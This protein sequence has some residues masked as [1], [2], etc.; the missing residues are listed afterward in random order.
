MNL[1][2]L[3]QTPDICFR[4]GT[5]RNLSVRKKTALAFIFIALAGC[6]SGKEQEEESERAKRFLDQ[7]NTLSSAVEQEAKAVEGKVVDGW[8]F[9]EDSRSLKSNYREV[10]PAIK[11]RFACDYMVWLQGK[12]ENLAAEW[13]SY[14]PYSQRADF[15]RQWWSNTEHSRDFVKEPHYKQVIWLHD[16]LMDGSELWFR[17]LEQECQA[18]VSS[19]LVMAHDREQQ[20]VAKYKEN[21]SSAEKSF[22]SF[23]PEPSDPESAAEKSDNKKSIDNN[24]TKNSST[25]NNSAD[26]DH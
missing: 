11:A 25:K 19:L 26:K 20:L 4:N 6:S 3:S 23:A 1:W 21:E 13:N 22:S 12:H 24:S 5:L 18:G 16:A 8:Y 7:P 15:A 10:D 14:V 9:S 17:A 2:L